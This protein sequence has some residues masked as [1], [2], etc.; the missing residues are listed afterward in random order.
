MLAVVVGNTGSVARL[1]LVDVERRIWINGSCGGVGRSRTELIRPQVNRCERPEGACKTEVESVHI[2][3]RQVPEA[4]SMRTRGHHSAD[5][6]ENSGHADT[7]RTRSNNMQAGVAIVLNSRA[8]GRTGMIA[9]R[10]P[11]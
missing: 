7:S 6:L 9:N 2:R 1:N 8:H 4:D 5:D 11:R 10:R 3:A